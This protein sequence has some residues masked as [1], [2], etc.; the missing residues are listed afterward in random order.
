[1]RS[2]VKQALSA[3][4]KR[5]ASN[6]VVGPELADAIRA[7]KALR[8]REFSTTI[9]MWNENA[10]A[11]AQNLSHCLAGIDAIAQERLDCYLSLKEQDLKFS[12]DLTAALFDHAGQ[13]KVSLHFDSQGP[14]DADQIF[15]VIERFRSQVHELGCTLPGRWRRSLA[16]V[17]RAAALD[18]RVRVVTGQWADP[19]EPNRD[20]RAGFLGVIDRLAGKVKHVAVATHNPV[21]A[22][23]ALDRLHATGTSAEMELLYGFPLRRVLPIA[24][25]AG[26]PV[27]IYIPYGYAWLPYT[28]GQIRR[29]P[30]IA[31]WVLQDALFSGQPRLPKPADAGRR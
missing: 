8:Q 10:D 22:L 12:P 17:E 3:L 18:L 31:F 19:G 26:V 14:E 23:R 20:P 28:F 30:R 15:S 16:D 6:Y 4:A 9:C 7:C 21:L 25:D 24:R 29:N 11:P 13:R 27:R 5:V 1:V 2:P